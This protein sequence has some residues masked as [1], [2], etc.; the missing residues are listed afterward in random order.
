M[1]HPRSPVRGTHKTTPFACPR[2]PRRWRSAFFH[3]SSIAS[4]LTRPPRLWATKI[5]GRDD[6]LQRTL[7][8][9]KSFRRFVAWSVSWFDEVTDLDV[10]NF[11]ITYASYP[12][13]S[14]RAVPSSAGRRLCGHGQVCPL[15]CQMLM[16]LPD[17][18]W[19]KQI[20]TAVSWQSCKASIPSAKLG[21]DYRSGTLSS[22][23]VAAKFGG[24]GT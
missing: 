2:I 5:K 4:L 16:R 13:V 11:D 9:V 14:M 24:G 22:V 12:K 15:A 3:D 6:A 19:M 18:S 8:F 23:L 10:A 21:F 17:R 7:S 1:S 20:S